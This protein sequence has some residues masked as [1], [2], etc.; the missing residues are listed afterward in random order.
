M[1]STETVRWL[2]KN[3]STI[4]RAMAKRANE[5]YSGIPRGLVLSDLRVC[6]AVSYM[7]DPPGYYSASGSVFEHGDL[8][9]V[10]HEAHVSRDGYDVIEYVPGQFYADEENGR[11]GMP[12]IK[13]LAPH[14]LLK[15]TNQ[16]YV[17]AGGKSEIQAAINIIYA[18]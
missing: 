9:P 2:A 3:T 11:S 1:V 15:L 13:S 17:L 14:L 18:L 6:H 7:P 5:M 12:S 16:V 4:E 10:Y 8:S